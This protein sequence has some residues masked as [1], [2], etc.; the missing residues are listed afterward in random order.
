MH[1]QVFVI[2]CAHEWHAIRAPSF[3]ALLVNHY[4]NVVH[5]NDKIAIT[6]HPR[7]D[8]NRREDRAEASGR[9]QL[10]AGRVQPARRRTRPDVRAHH[11][12]LHQGRH[13]GTWRRPRTLCDVTLTWRSGYAVNVLAD[14]W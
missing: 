10:A 13:L 4:F 9:V 12:L 2:Y 3:A 8:A 7:T 14:S 1:W 6:S 11:R 5:F